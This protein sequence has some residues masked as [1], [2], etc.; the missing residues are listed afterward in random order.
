MEAASATGNSPS[1]RVVERPSNT[2]HRFPFLAFDPRGRVHIPLTLFASEASRRLSKSTARAYVSVLNLFFLD[3]LQ[4]GNVWDAAP[5]VVRRQI[6]DHLRGRLECKVRPHRL[7][8]EVVNL[9]DRSATSVR[10]FL[11]AAK[12]FYRVMYESKLYPDQNPLVQLTVLDQR[13]TA[14]NVSR[15]TDPIRVNQVLENRVITV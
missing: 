9:T 10:M 13:G 7:G 1:F 2:P 3:L 5:D 4:D 15:K 14:T 6:A 11:S 8:I 12:L